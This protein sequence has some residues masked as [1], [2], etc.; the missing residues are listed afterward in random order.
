MQQ[1]QTK[2]TPQK[3]DASKSK[4]TKKGVQFSFVVPEKKYQMYAVILLVLGLCCFAATLF[5]GSTDHTVDNLK[6][7]IKVFDQQ[8]GSIEQQFYINKMR[9]SLDEDMNIALHEEDI[10]RKTVTKEDVME[11][12]NEY[13]FIEDSEKI[14]EELEPEL[15]D[16]TF[17]EI[18]EDEEEDEKDEKQPEIIEKK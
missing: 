3:V 4:K 10:E 18:V 15:D 14:I 1:K 5:I 9:E 17:G 12:F 6:N 16:D 11:L 7:S 13:G 8:D 2:E